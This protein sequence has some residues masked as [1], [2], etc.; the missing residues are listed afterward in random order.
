M[1]NSSVGI[2][3]SVVICALIII[4]CLLVLAGN[5]AP[6]SLSTGATVSTRTAAQLFSKHCATC[7]GK[8]G[9]AKTFKAKFNHAR[10]L[11]E[12]GWQEAV[13][14]ERIFNSI[15]NGRGK[16]MPAFGKKITE[17]EI[18]SLVLL[19]RGMRSS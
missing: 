15:T 14:D 4:S 6:A 5:G 12:P 2:G 3:S 7:H 17:A 1:R 13:S 18:N 19:V 16:K 8:D 9:R 11:T 10:N